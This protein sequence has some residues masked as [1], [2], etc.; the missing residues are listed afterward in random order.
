MAF[1]FK[2][3]PNKKSNENHLARE[4]YYYFWFL[5]QLIV[6]IEWHPCWT[7]SAHGAWQ[8]VRKATARSGTVRPKSFPILNTQIK[9]RRKRV[10]KECPPSHPQRNFNA[11]IWLASLFMD[12]AKW[13]NWNFAYH[14]FA[15][16]AR[17][18][19]SIAPYVRTSLRSSSC[20]D[21]SS[22]SSTQMGR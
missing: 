7:F 3:E 22:C 9:I 16:D 10:W 20:D 13:T 4:G 8:K 12:P 2:C 1:R 21:E 15:L 17:G 6:I 11:H 5:F 14:K 18:A 19:H